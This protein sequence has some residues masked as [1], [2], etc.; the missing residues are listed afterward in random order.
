MSIF[1]RESIYRKMSEVNPRKLPKI[2]YCN[3]KIYIFSNKQ[4]SCYDINNLKKRKPKG[5]G[6]YG[7]WLATEGI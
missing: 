4:Q 3:L 6:L 2:V 1:N 5:S 7:A